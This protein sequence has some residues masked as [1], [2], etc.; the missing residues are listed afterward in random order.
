[1]SDRSTRASQPQ[2]TSI[3]IPGAPV[4]PGL[5]FRH[6][7]G[8]SDFAGIAR[9]RQACTLEDRGDDI[10]T[11]ADI[12][13]LIENPCHTDPYRDMVLAEVDGLLVAMHWSSASVL[14]GTF[15][16]GLWGC[17]HP[18]W[19]R[20]GLGR[21]LMAHGEERSRINIPLEDTS[22]PAVWQAEASSLE[23]GAQALFRQR[24][25]TP[26]RYAY[27]MTRDLADPIPSL[28]LPPGIEVRP[29]RPEHYRDIWEAEREAF[30]DAWG[31]TP[32][33]EEN[34]QRFL[35]FPH[36]DPTLW[37][38]AWAGNQ[39]AGMVISFVNAEENAAAGRSRGY[40]EDIA[41]RRP[42][43]RQGL[44]SALLADSLRA[45]QALGLAEA[46]L[47]VDAE[48]PNQALSL[49]Q[50]LGFSIASEWITLRRQ[51]PSKAP[52]ATDSKASCP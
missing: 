50:R 42:W 25:Y 32:W 11:E 14:G 18:T 44:A 34:Y 16:V 28:A 24:G 3:A 43:R 26:F 35:K 38:V 47:G 17:V 52:S 1:M 12:A 21:A 45:L 22:L 46:A 51:W 5:R 15:V 4:I 2:G 40:T 8:P 33:L 19:R 20:R 9:L 31:Y 41:V 6:L 29:A 36:Y 48:N 27:T 30:Q 49:Y 37:R 7:A 39:V 10:L 13:N 23:T